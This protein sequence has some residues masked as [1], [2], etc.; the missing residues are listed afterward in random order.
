MFY[1]PEE[2]FH[3]ALDLPAESVDVELLL[4]SL[5]ILL[6]RLKAFLVRRQAA[7]QTLWVRLYHYDQPATLIRIGLLRPVTDPAYLLELTRIQLGDARLCAPVI[8][9][10]VQTD[11]IVNCAY[12]GRD[13]FGMSPDSAGKSIELIERLRTR[14][15]AQSVFGLRTIAEHR[16]ESAWASVTDLR[17]SGEN[18]HRYQPAA[19]RPVWML[20]EPLKLQVA[21]G[22]PVY[23]DVLDL[24]RGPERI[25]TGWWDGRDIRRDYYVARDARGARLWVFRDYRESAWYLHGLFG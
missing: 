3:D 22:K 4:E 20:A 5:N 19:E 25:E 17:G 18:D 24:G 12:Q 13:L 23:R 9:V 10:L 7:V 8:A 1:T 21:Q 14:L 6:V 2:R 16:P 15:G 11:A